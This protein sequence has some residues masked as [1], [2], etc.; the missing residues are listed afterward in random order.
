MANPKG[1]PPNLK[2]GENT[3]FSGERA[4]ECGSRGG[5][6]TAINRREAK[7]FAAAMK[8]LLKEKASREDMQKQLEE[9][10]YENSK[11]GAI[12][13]NFLQDLESDADPQKLKVVLDVVGESPKINIGISAEPSTAEEL[14]N[15]SDEEL[16]KLA[17]R[18]ADVSN[19]ES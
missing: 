4:V 10:G 14:R 11:L 1:Y 17:E 16:R 7:T 8:L 19:S 15:L 9:M 13:L 5:K 3:Q 6:Q 18:N 12:C 2:N